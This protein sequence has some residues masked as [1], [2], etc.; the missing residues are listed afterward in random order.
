MN[1]CIATFFFSSQCELG[2]SRPFCEENRKFCRQLFGVRI[3]SFRLAS[4][5]DLFSACN[6]LA[7]FKPQGLVPYGRFGA[8]QGRDAITKVGGRGYCYCVT[9]EFS[10]FSESPPMAGLWHLC[11]L[12]SLV[13]ITFLRDIWGENVLKSK[14]SRGWPLELVFGDSR[15]ALSQGFTRQNVRSSPE[16]WP[17]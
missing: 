6:R 9:T 14:F 2:S 11:G 17:E 1:L 8:L 10:R 3:A 7:R 12:A 5:S 15:K 16:K 13:P 4:D